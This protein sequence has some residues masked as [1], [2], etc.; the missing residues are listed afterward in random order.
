VLTGTGGRTIKLRLLVRFTVSGQVP[1]S[2]AERRNKVLDVVSTAIPGG[3]AAW[4]VELSGWA[5]ITEKLSVTSCLPK[6][7]RFA[8][9]I[10]S[11]WLGWFWRGILYNPNPFLIWPW[12]YVVYI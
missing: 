8:Q 3:A 4:N 7:A 9:S 10:S 5:T 2:G 6:A 12:M 1:C 11:A